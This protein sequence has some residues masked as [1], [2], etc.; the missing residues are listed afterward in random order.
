MA[1]P[2][3]VGFFDSPGDALKVK[4]ELL[5]AGVAAHRI[6]VGDE[7]I[8]GDIP[9]PDAFGEA[10]PS[11]ACVVAVVARSHV[12]KKNIAELMRRNGAR[13]TLEAPP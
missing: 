2:T 3:V 10:L 12:D 5:D 7:A 11:G 8:V 6:V 9:A 13:G 4:D 1:S